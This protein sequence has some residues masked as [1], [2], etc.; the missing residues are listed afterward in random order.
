[1][2]PWYPQTVAIGADPRYHQ[3]VALAGPWGFVALIFLRAWGGQAISTFVPDE[4]VGPELAHAEVPA[5]KRAATIEAL[6]AVGYLARREGGYE[7][8]DFSP[9]ARQ[10]E[11]V[12][13]VSD[14]GRRVKADRRESY[15][16]QHAEEIKAKDRARKASRKPVVESVVECRGTASWNVVESVVESTTP[17]VV[18]SDRSTTFRDTPAPTLS[19]PDPPPAPAPT[20]AQAQAQ[21]QAHEGAPGGPAL[22]PRVGEENQQE[23]PPSQAPEAAS[24]PAAAAPKAK[25]R[26]PRALPARSALAAAYAAGV[27]AATGAPCSPPSARWD[28]TALEAMAQVHAAGRVGAELLGW[29]TEQGRDFAIAKAGDRF[30][31]GKG[32][33]PEACRGWLD[34]GAV[35]RPAPPKAP[36]PPPA[37][38]GP[39]PRR[40]GQPTAPPVA[41]TPQT[42]RSFAAYAGQLFAPKPNRTVSPEARALALAKLSAVSLP[43]DSEAAR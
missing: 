33:T 43:P 23:S 7:L 40:E 36:G 8:L 20:P 4:Q 32:Y 6:L 39:H 26:K 35:D 5:S 13:A 17:D 2:R 11:T 25:P 3:L 9:S 16:Q 22:P 1:M 38:S 37:S 27:S 24:P 14:G 19:P 31:A 41:A 10:G 15:R 29:L 28:L 42:P 12:E 18:E 34:G 21:A 30:L